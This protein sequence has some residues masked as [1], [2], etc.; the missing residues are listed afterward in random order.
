MGTGV[1]FWRHQAGIPQATSSPRA[2]P[3]TKSSELRRSLLFHSP[4]HSG[5][6]MLTVRSL[7]RHPFRRLQR[8]LELFAGSLSSLCS[9][10]SLQNALTLFTSWPLV[11]FHACPCTSPCHLSAPGLKLSNSFP[12]SAVALEPQSFTRRD[13]RPHEKCFYVCGHVP[14]ENRR[15]NTKR[16]ELKHV[17]EGITSPLITLQLSEGG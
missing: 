11:S 10:L 6:P 15:K 3:C 17:D 13:W 14:N 9:L 4:G 7:L 5:S 12:G 2:G 1:R 8:W 16:K